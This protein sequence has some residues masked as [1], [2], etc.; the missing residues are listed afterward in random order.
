MQDKVARLDVLDI[1]QNL[2]V[3]SVLLNFVDISRYSTTIVLFD[4]KIYCFVEQN[5]TGR[6]FVLLGGE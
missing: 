6:H 3:D 4:N 2:P 1:C 5:K